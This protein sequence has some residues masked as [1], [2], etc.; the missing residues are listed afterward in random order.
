MSRNIDTDRYLTL[1]NRVYTPSKMR[2][3]SHQS[4]EIL[5]SPFKSTTIAFDEKKRVCNCKNSKC[6]KLYCECFA[7]GNYCDS[8][9]CNCIGCGNNPVNTAFYLGK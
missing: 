5:I 9:V 4:P 1:K 7:S 3:N 8:Q 2:Y 6:L